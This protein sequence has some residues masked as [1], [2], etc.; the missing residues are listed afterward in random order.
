MIG[1]KWSYCA[2]VFQQIKTG[3]TKNQ[4][5][6][7]LVSPYNR[8]NKEGSLTDL[9]SKQFRGLTWNVRLFFQPHKY[10]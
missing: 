2:S 8:N 7:G 6:A 1:F 5:I 4:T 9:N 10:I 3:S